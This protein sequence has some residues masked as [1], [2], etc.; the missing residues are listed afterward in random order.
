MRNGTREVILKF[1][2]YLRILQADDKPVQAFGFQHVG[3][4]KNSPFKSL[5]PLF[6]YLI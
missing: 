2:Y 1:I 6:P 3:K 5:F 4:K